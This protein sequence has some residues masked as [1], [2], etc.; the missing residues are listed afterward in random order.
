MPA[1]TTTSIRLPPRLTRELER[2]AKKT[3]RGKN[4]VVKEALE[5]YLLGSAHDQLKEE[6]KRQSLQ[7][8]STPADSAWAERGGDFGDWK[9]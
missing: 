1:S 9:A 7:A 2:R 8:R 4:W 6:A 3:K 5:H